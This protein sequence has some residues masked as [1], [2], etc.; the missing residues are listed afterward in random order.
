M[1]SQVWALPTGWPVSSLRAVA[2][3]RRSV[4]LRYHPD[5][6][7][8]LRFPLGTSEQWLREFIEAKRGWVEG[9]ITRHQ[10]RI[11]QFPPPAPGT[12]Y[13]RGLAI[14]L[15]H[16]D[17]PFPRRTAEGL[18]LN[19]K[20]SAEQVETRLRSFL[21]SDLQER[22]KLEVERLGGGVEGVSI[23]RMKSRWGSCSRNGSIR[24]NEALAHLEDRCL[25]YV[26]CHEW[27]HRSEFHH[28]PAFYAALQ[29]L[30]PSHREDERLLH[31][32]TPVL[33]YPVFERTHGNE[34][35]DPSDRLS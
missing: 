19:L 6:G 34:K 25:R 3:A 21:R 10:H 23:R 17:A 14:P 12:V 27:A 31:H 13:L 1:K 9:Q 29:E 28:G 4:A 26:V 7:L 33:R 16:S 32:R 18:Y 30:L 15:F 8:E 24:V 22:I 35:A 2:S 20:G 5:S 11:S